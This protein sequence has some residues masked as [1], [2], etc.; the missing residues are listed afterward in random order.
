MGKVILYHL[1]LK[2]ES[3]FMPSESNPIQ[4]LYLSNLFFNRFIL[5][6]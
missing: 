1:G 2:G 4:C 6:F 5:L 3:Q